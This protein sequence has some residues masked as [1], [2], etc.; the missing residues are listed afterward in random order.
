MR[1]FEY[2]SAPMR[3]ANLLFDMTILNFLWLLSCIPILTIGAATAAQFEV[4]RQR[5][6][7]D[8]HIFHNYKAAFKKHFKRSTI[9]WLI[10]FVL[11]AAFYMDYHM[12]TTAE[13]PGQDVLMVISVLAFVALVFVMLWSYPVMISFKGNIREI[14]FNAFVFSFMYAPISLI[15][16]GIYAL[17]GYLMLRFLPARVLFIVFGHALIVYC[18]LTLFG[19]VF[20]R[21]SKSGD[22]EE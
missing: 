13:V 10:F 3:F 12:L 1:A 15:A 22:L 11:S 19:M 16:I 17:A 14:L 4:C 9:M 21:Y 5:M 6:E 7:G 8:T 2:D 20:K 18:N